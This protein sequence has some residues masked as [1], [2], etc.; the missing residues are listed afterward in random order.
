[1]NTAVQT[2]NSSECAGFFIA[3]EKQIYSEIA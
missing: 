3:R 1:M 2:E